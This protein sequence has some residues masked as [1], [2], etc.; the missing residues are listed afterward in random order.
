MFIITGGEAKYLFSDLK[1]VDPMEK[2]WPI[3]NKLSLIKAGISKSLFLTDKNTRQA[4]FTVLRW[5]AAQDQDTSLEM[6][7]NL[8]RN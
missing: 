2:N 1:P 3:K 4:N 8:D 7:R 6:E 5:L